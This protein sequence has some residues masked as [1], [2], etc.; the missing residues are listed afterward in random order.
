MSGPPSA[1]P[2]APAVSSRG[3]N[4]LTPV[5]SRPPPGSPMAAVVA[6][7]VQ[8]SHGLAPYPQQAL[9]PHQLPPLP[10]PS[11]PPGARAPL[12]LATASSPR[13]LVAQMPNQTRKAWKKSGPTISRASGLLL[14]ALAGL[15]ILG[16]L[17]V[18]FSL[19]E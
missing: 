1:T 18:V 6:H 9:L 8:P 13:P 4:T 2:S 5:P 14:L 12:P 10:Q 15:V 3:S 16:G 17:F 7:E 19:L 11:G